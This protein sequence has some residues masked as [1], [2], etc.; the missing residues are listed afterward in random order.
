MGGSEAAVPPDGNGQGLNLERPLGKLV[1]PARSS[2]AES[3]TQSNGWV[4]CRALWSACFQTPTSALCHCL[5]AA[6][7]AWFGAVDLCIAEQELDF[8]Q[9]KYNL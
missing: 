5:V 3:R 1:L 4:V 6:V 2:L 7:V 9:I 8:K